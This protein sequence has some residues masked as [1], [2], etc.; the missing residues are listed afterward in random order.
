MN[1]P[2]RDSKTSPEIIRLAVTMYARYPLSLREVEDILFERGI[3]VSHETIWCWLN[4]RA[5]DSNLPLRMRE[6]AIARFRDIKTL[7]SF[8]AI[9]GSTY[10][11]F[12]HQRSLNRL[13]IFSSSFE[14]PLWP[15]GVDR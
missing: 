4:N 2:L 3:D 11:L 9:H 7:Q 5:D 15:S 6:G 14:P 13:H 12:N 1:N 8:G 10:N